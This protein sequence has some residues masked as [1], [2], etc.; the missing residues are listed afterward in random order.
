MTVIKIIDTSLANFFS[1]KTLKSKKTGMN[2][3]LLS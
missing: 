3:V 2:F 1:I